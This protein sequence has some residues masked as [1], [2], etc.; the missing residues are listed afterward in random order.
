MKGFGMPHGTPWMRAGVLVLALFL[1][2]CAAAISQ[3][4]RDEV[5]PGLTFSKV[6]SDPLSHRG[7]V[8]LWGG[9][10]LQ[11]RNTSDQ[12]WIEI[13]QRPLTGND[14]PDRDEPSQGRFLIR[15]EGFLDPAIY[16]PGREITV[17]G[18]VAGG[19]ERTLG[20]IQYRYPVVSDMQMVL[21]GPR[22]EPTF[23]FG[24]GLGTHF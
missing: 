17:V 2:G 18:K 22:R 19:E 4:V 11:A 16:G 5:E 12:T 6:F 14:R 13:L 24:L 21:W 10:I 23:H 20:E 8:V 9:E 15:H 7:K 1:D 3:Q